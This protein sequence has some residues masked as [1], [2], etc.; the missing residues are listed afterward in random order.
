MFC[1]IIGV[2]RVKCNFLFSFDYILLQD[3]QARLTEAQ[4]SEEIMLSLGRSVIGEHFTNPHR[5]TISEKLTRFIQEWSNL[6]L[7]WQNWYDEL[8]ASGIHSQSLSENLDKFKAVLRMVNTLSAEMLP[9][10]LPM[11]S[12]DVELRNVEV[13][14]CRELF[15]AMYLCTFLL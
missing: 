15:R 6:S 8:Y 12:A 2:S 9:A 10:S 3:F 14:Y 11:V 5:D 1:I 7:A 4:A 13:S